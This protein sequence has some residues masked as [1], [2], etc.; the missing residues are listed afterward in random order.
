MSGGGGGGRPP[1]P[2]GCAHVYAGASVSIF[3]RA[4][5]QIRAPDSH[6]HLF[7]IHHAPYMYAN[8][9][10]PPSTPHSAGPTSE[11]RSGSSGTSGGS[12]LHSPGQSSLSSSWATQTPSPGMHGWACS[13]VCVY[14]GLISSLSSANEGIVAKIC[15]RNTPFTSSRRTP[16]HRLL[17]ATHAHAPY[18]TAWL[19]AI[20]SLIRKN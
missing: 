19:T 15:A 10:V 17:H 1:P 16:T 3:A 14:V 12:T 4:L 5:W 2:N 6:R 9:V 11:R 20:S 13:S 18:L 7:A 8:G